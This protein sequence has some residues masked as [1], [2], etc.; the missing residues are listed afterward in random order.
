LGAGF[1][2]F[3]TEQSSGAK[4]KLDQRDGFGWERNLDKMVTVLEGLRNLKEIW[5]VKHLNHKC[6]VEQANE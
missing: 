1:E 2:Q 6:T 3:R 4:K 5:A